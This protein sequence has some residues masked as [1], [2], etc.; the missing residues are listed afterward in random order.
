MKKQQ[1][2][3]KI[4][5]QQQEVESTL[6]CAREVMDMTARFLCSLVKHSSS[7]DHQ[8]IIYSLA[9][10]Y[11]QMEQMINDRLKINFGVNLIEPTEQT[12][13]CEIVKE[14]TIAFNQFKQMI[15]E[16]SIE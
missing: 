12:I 14:L 6:L 13:N 15:D 9:L 10:S 5:F 11:A 2:N 1:S 7:H 3:K 8:N 4:F 16:A